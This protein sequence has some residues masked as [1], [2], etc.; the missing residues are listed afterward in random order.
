LRKSHSLHGLDV[1]Y[2]VEVI[3]NSAKL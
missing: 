1:N 3:V 2:R